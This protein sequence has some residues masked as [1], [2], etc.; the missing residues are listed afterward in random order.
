MPFLHELQKRMPLRMRS[1][2][3][4]LLLVLGSSLVNAQSV[5]DGA[6]VVKAS[7]EV[8]AVN[9]LLSRSGLA[10]LSVMQF[11]V[12]LPEGVASGA[13]W[14]KPLSLQT[15]AD[16]QKANPDLFVS[17]Q[18]FQVEGDAATVVL[19]VNYDRLTSAPQVAEIKLALK[20]KGAVWTVISSQINKQ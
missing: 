12:A 8:P 19:K 1:S 3:F 14:R 2:F 17:F 9:E 7:F 5:P 4:L 10:K 16:I 15:R 13:N 11:P 20:K 6:A 18:S